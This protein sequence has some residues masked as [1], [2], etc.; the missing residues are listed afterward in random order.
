MIPVI[1]FFPDAYEIRS[2][3]V[4]VIRAWLL[5]VIIAVVRHR[6]VALQLPGMRVIPMA[7]H[8]V[9][10]FPVFRTLDVGD[11][12]V[13]DSDEELRTDEQREQPAAHED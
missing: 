5:R 10:N 8:T 13:M 2:F 6:Q 12:P 1:G 11:R 3:L 4:P 7:R 9:A